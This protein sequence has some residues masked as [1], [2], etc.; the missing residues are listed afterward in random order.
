MKSIYAL[1]DYKGVFGSK[2]FDT[3]YRSGFEKELL[4]KYFA[5]ENIKLQF[6]RFSDLDFKN[7]DFKNE[8]FIYT[9]SEDDNYLYKSFIEDLILGLELK[10]ALVIPKFKYLRSNNN[11]V[12]MEILRDSFLFPNLSS[13][14]AHYFGTKEEF[15]SVKSKIKEP[16]VIKTSEGASGKGVFLS[17]SNLDTS[18]Y[19]KQVSRSKNILFELRDL[20]R[21]KKHKGYITESKY[22][23]KFIVQEFVQ[24]LINDWKVYVFGKR[25]Y[26][27]YRPV[28]KKRG[29][30]ASG[31]GYD[32]YFYGS[33]AMIP[34]G[35]FDF[36]NEVFNLLNVPHVSL[37]IGY[38]GKKFYLFEFQCLYF[39]TAGIPYSNE[40]FIKRDNHWENV[41]ERLDQEKVYTDSIIDFLKK[42]KSC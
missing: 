2:H 20:G 6:I 18:K 39:G 32:N 11:K 19:V 29:I 4:I 12:F 14:S 15:D 41:K 21:A 40:Y 5:K 3:P 17:K 27:F 34:D 7:K 31:G 22:R 23:K 37:D 24:G 36:A 30:K 33:N 1:T 9:S 25:L 38:D 10:E 42:A 35:L 28:F 13:L 8:I 26:V 16:F